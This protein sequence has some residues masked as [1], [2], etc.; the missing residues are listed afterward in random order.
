MS[1]EQLVN[2]LCQADDQVVNELDRKI[3]ELEAQ[4]ANL[5]RVRRLLGGKPGGGGRIDAGIAI[6]RT[7]FHR[8]RGDSEQLLAKMCEVLKAMGPLRAKELATEVG[9]TN[10]AYIGRL[11][12]ATQKIRKRDDG[13]FEL[14]K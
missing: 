13:C 5:K 9:E 3:A 2:V 10:F 11:A 4:L 6:R 12:A 14:A 8:S 7:I 1:I